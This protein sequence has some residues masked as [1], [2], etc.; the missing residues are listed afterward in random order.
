MKGFGPRCDRSGVLPS[1]VLLPIQAPLLRLGANW[2]S[3]DRALMAPSRIHYSKNANVLTASEQATLLQR[4][5]IGLP[6]LLTGAGARTDQI[7]P[8]FLEM[9]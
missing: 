3:S 5:E 2:L 4:S 6:W 8:G 9:A 1:V 7:P